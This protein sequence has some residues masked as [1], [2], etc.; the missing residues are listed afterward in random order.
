[1]TTKLREITSYI[2]ELSDERKGIINKL[3]KVITENLPEGFEEAFSYKMI[4]YVVP[5]DIYPKGYHC[6]PSLPL[7]FINLASQKNFVAIYHMGIYSDEALLN[8]FKKEY[9]KYC[10]KKIDMGKSCIR[11]KNMKTIPYTLIGELA[12]KMTV[13]E[14]ISTYTRNIKQ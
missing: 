12:A 10:S 13:E 4:G 5:H 7:P 8:W 3:R 9:P 11:F 2:E 6:D 14:W 1:M